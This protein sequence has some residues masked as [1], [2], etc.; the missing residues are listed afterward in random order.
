MLLFDQNISYRIIPELSDYYPNCR[1][2]R[3]FGLSNA[4]DV[5]IWD[6]ARKNNYTIVTFDADFYDISL[7]N[8]CPPK[9]VWLRTGNLTTNKLSDLLKKRQKQIVD[10]CNQPEQKEKACLEIYLDNI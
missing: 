1:Q 10:F 7:I 5:D 9:I 8:G 2:V 3:E 6:Y 4:E